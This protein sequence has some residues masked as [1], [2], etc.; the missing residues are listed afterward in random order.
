M[1]AYPIWF[2]S[3]DRPLSGWFHQPSDRRARA[4]AVLCAPFGLEYLQ[5]HYALRLLGERLESLGICALRFDYDGMGDSAG[6]STD[7]H[8]VESWLRSAAQAIGVLRDAGV[9]TVS[10]VGMRMGALIA[11]IV[12]KDSDVDQIV[13]WDPCVS[14]RSF[15]KQQQAL[16]AL[17]LGIRARRPDG[18]VEAPGL[19]YGA[20]T[21]AD[22]GRLDLSALSNTR[23]RRTLVLTRHDRDEDSRLEGLTGTGTVDREE[24]VGQAELMDVGAPGQK[25]PFT[26]IE[27]IA[28]WLSDGTTEISQPVDAPPAAASATVGFDASGNA[29]VERPLSV[30]PAGLF[31]MVT[32]PVGASRGPAV[33]MLS[34]ANEHHIG[35]N[36]LWVDLAR[37]WAEAG[38]GSLRLDLSGLGESPLRHPQQRRFLSGAPE[39]FADVEDASRAMSPEDP[40]NVVLV[41]LCASGYQAIESALQLAPR[42]VIALNPALSMFPPEF[43]LGQPLDRRRAVALPIGSAVQAFRDQ[44]PLSAFRRRFPDLGWRLRLLVAGARRPAVWLKSLVDDGVDVLIVCGESEG[45]PIRLGTTGRVL[46]RLTACGR[47]EFNYFSDLEHGLLIASQRQMVADL[48]TNHLTSKF[49]GAQKDPSSLS[50]VALS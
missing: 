35:P 25:L 27:R 26:A 29:I 4:G 7:G 44:G 42:G 50:G 12:A 10:L 20:D 14:G 16:S 22:L 39:A 48:L 34:V 40:S 23:V 18:S 2:G 28:A 32:E 11:A 33:L 3:T 45:R 30:P 36:R 15:L 31:G 46:A 47:F 13:L 43:E 24:A 37:R 17:S 21:V 38:V 6:S 1:T 41:G 8:R 49:V 9:P 5:A 19:V